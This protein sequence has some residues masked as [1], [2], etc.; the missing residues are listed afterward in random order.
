MLVCLTLVYLQ[1]SA[2]SSA[3]APQPVKKTS[4]ES[5]SANKGNNTPAPWEARPNQANKKKPTTVTTKPNTKPEQPQP[6]QPKK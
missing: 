4:T 1:S 5:S 3:A 2:Q 6:I